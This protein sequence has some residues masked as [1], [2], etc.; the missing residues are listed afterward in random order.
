VP[1]CPSATT[2][3]SGFTLIEILVVIAVVAILAS[4]VSPMVFR[5]VSDARQAAAR[6]QIEIF[7]LALDTYRLDNG[8]YPT[9]EQGIS[10]LRVAPEAGAP[11]WR[12]PYVRKAIPLDPWDRPYAYLSPGV[13]NPNSYDLSSLG[14]DGERD[15]ED[16]DADIDSWR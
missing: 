14:Q 8:T 9:S 10:A 12:G 7:G 5:N 6:A 2:A 3:S 13:A 1:R 4:L 15:G 11:R 16:E